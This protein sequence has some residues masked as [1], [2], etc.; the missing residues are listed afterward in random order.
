MKKVVA[1]RF[2]GLKEKQ[3]KLII[4]YSVLISFRNEIE[5]MTFSDEGQLRQFII[6]RFT[7]KIVS[8]EVSSS[9]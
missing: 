2:K 5:I 8:K 6:K 1:K 4:L 9:Y 7:L 3:W